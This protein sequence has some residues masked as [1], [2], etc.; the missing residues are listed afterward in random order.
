[1]PGQQHNPNT[2]IEDVVAD[3]HRRG[4]ER[5]EQEYARLLA[6][7]RSEAQR[8]IAEAQSSK[9]ALIAEGSREAQRLVDGANTQ[10]EQLLRA[11][12]AS[13]PAMFTRRAEA[14]LQQLVGNT[15]SVQRDASSLRQFVDSIDPGDLSR[16]KHHLDTAQPQTFVEALLLMALVFYANNDG[17]ARFVVDANLQDRLASL[18]ADPALHTELPFEF[19]KDIPGFTLQGH[20]G[21]EIEVSPDSVAHMVLTWAQDEYRDVFKRVLAGEPPVEPAQDE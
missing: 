15:F 18:L 20:N 21:N 11:F 17:F 16:L 12:L 5:G 10:A 13:L 1:M 3:L 2:A 8:I 9:Q 19:R 4:V 6:Q 7:G 14:L